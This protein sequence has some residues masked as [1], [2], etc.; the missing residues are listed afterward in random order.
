M[1]E[2]TCLCQ[3]LQWRIKTPPEAAYHCHCTMCR[4]IH[5]AAF[6]TYYIID[7]NGFEW[8]SSQDSLAVFRS[9]ENLSRNFCNR[10]GSVVPNA[11]DDG[12]IWYV[13]AGSHTDGPPVESHIFTGSKASWH[14]I[15]DNL[16]QHETFPPGVEDAVCNTPDRAEKRTDVLS[17]SCLCQRVLF[18]VESNFSAVHNCH[19]NR[20]RRARA[21]AHTTNGFIAI[22]QFEWVSGEDNTEV[23][24]LSDARFFT[25]AFCKTCGSGV[26]RTDL[27]RGIAI[28]PFGTLDDDPGRG[29]DD[30][31]FLNSK[32]SWYEVEDSL[33][34]Y[35][36]LPPG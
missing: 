17:G 16:Q 10:C 6:A 32:A 23:Y 3:R 24:K 12:S 28:V 13:P 8:T 25:H 35:G 7:T 21:A 31:I 5:A 11:S 19:C 27:G 14:E 2:G 22:D 1:S 29:A 20:C 34:A 33:P 4:K 9:S 30:H 15:A 36:E 26:P 18:R